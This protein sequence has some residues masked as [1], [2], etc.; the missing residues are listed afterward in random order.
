M[1][2]GDVE[3]AMKAYEIDF[4]A[5]SFDELYQVLKQWTM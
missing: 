5:S 3:E 1:P 4:A 2:E